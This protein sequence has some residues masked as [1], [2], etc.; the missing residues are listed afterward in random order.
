M[1]YYYFT[2]FLNEIN[3]W[4]NRKMT[5]IALNMPNDTI[6]QIKPFFPTST[7]RCESQF[8]TSINTLSKVVQWNPALWPPLWYGHLVITATFF[9]RLVKTAIHFLEK[10]KT[11]V[12]TATPLIPPNVFGPFGDGINGVP[13][14]SDCTK[15]SVMWTFLIVSV[16]KNTKTTSKLEIRYYV[17]L[18]SKT[19]NQR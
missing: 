14:Y 12:N 6:D 3:F 1:L 18:I 19:L 9:V 11:L 17:L 5:C 4:A 2:S 7:G 13:L 16:L 10:K 15:E 8:L